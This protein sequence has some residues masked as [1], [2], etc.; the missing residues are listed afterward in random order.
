MAIVNNITESNRRRD[1]LSNSRNAFTAGANVIVLAVALI[2]F[3]TMDN[4]VD[5]YRLLCII[6]LSIG[7]CASMFYMFHIREVPLTEASAKYDKAYK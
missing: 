2:L 4:A 7:A 6:A 1:R 3:A 5:E